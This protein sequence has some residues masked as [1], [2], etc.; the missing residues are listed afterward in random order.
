MDNLVTLIRGL[1]ISESKFVSESGFDDAVD[2]IVEIIEKYRNLDNLEYEFRLGYIE[3]KVFNTEIQDEFYNKIIK[4]LKTN[5][6]WEVIDNIEIMD[7]FIG[8][9]RHSVPTSGETKTIKK[10]KLVQ[11]D[12]RYQNTPFDIRFSISK[13]DP[14]TKKIKI[15]DATYTRK[16]IRTSFKHKNWLYDISKIETTTNG[17][18]ELTNEVELDLKIKPD[19]DLKH[20]IL[21]SLLKIGDLANMC[22]KHQG[23]EKLEFM[24]LQEKRK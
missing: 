20:I 24:H 18:K 13:E 10:T 23:T 19:D 6:K 11:M 3:D 9:L 16:K 17:V 22:E 5:T 7:Y 15:D 14:V 12:F 4:K 1:N 8:D 2:R 21:S